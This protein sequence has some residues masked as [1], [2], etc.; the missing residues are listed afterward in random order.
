MPGNPRLSILI[1][2]FNRKETTL[3]CLVSLK[4]A[5][6]D[7]LDYKVFVVDDGSSDGTFES[8][9]KLYPDVRIVRGSGNLYW[10][11]GMRRAWVEAQP[12]PTDYYLWLNDDLAPLPGTLWALV[13]YSTEN[14]GRFHGKLIVVGR[15]VSPDTG[16]TTYGG[17]KRRNG[18]SRLRFRHL[19]DDEVL[20]D[21][22][23]GNCVLIPAAATTDVGINDERF[24]HAFGDVDYGLRAVR[25]GYTILQM[26][27]PV[28]KQSFNDQYKRSISRMTL[29]NARFILTHPKGIPLIEW[30][31]FCRSNG[32][33]LWL[34]NFGLRYFKMLVG[35][36]G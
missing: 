36:G 27:Q 2:C 32:G 22:M 35:K 26:P 4:A 6:T 11:R 24:S 19:R 9:T 1:T 20:C 17:Y 18:I 30:F 28:G 10:N 29:R 16:Q 33:P 8:I 23:N 12:T 21:T 7:A 14:A 34:V 25:A 5:C 31:A 13:Q 3:A 15:T